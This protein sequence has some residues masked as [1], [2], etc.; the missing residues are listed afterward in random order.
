MECITLVQLHQL[1]L[2]E[3]C[4]LLDHM[5]YIII[6]QDQLQLVEEQYMQQRV[7]VKELD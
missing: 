6:A 4:Q 2:V 3:Q 7:M 1:T 5:E